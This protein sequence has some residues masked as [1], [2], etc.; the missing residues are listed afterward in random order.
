[1]KNKNKKKKENT[2]KAKMNGK[3]FIKHPLYKK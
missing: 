2:E 3:S 1:M